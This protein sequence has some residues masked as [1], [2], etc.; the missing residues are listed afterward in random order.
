M[1]AR[2][3]RDWAGRPAF[4]IGGGPSLTGFDFERLRGR[5]IIVAINDAVR[6]VPFA[7]VAFTIDT[8]W[9]EKRADLLR[10]FPGEIVAAVPV[11][12][13]CPVER[14]RLFRRVNAGGVSAFDDTLFTG[15]NS[16]FA[17]LAMAIKRGASPIH[18]L[19]YDMTA[20]GHWHR[21]YSWRSRFG[22][23]QYPKWAVRFASLAGLAQS[24]GADVINCNRSSAVTAFRHVTIDESLECLSP[25]NIS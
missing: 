11:N 15:G 20:A 25:A 8:V 13:Q 10:D 5:G 9:L 7:D 18:L 2:L 12:Y 14:A 3:E 24:L 1:F 21:G 4:L 6:Y 19:G 17:A 16:G 23:L 22:V